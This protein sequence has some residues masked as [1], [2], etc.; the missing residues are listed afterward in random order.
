LHSEFKMKRHKKPW[1]WDPRPRPY[2]A[3]GH[4]TRGP[5]PGGGGSFVFKC[6]FFAVILFPKKCAFMALVGLFSALFPLILREQR[7]PT[8]PAPPLPPTRPRMA[9]T[10]TLAI[11]MSS[12]PANW[13]S[14]VSSTPSAL[15]NIL[16]SSRLS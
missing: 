13:L 16:L 10:T 1:S 8:P 2:M 9:M 14:F 12:R 4:F 5:G 6:L 7:G 15:G 11:W 3:A